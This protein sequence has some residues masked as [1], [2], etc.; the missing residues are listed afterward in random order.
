MSSQQMKMAI[1][2]SDI[3]QPSWVSGVLAWISPWAYQEPNLVIRVWLTYHSETPLV[4][5]ISPAHS[6]RLLPRHTGHALN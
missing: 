4:T 2:V 3:S 5:F 1:V 6:P